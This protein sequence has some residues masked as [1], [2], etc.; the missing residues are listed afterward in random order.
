MDTE[1][2]TTRKVL[3]LDPRTHEL[4]VIY[5][6]FSI[7]DKEIAIQEIIFLPDVCLYPHGDRR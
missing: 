1:I 4:M 6:S 5:G 3:S 7:S 2:L